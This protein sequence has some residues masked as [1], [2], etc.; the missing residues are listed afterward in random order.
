[1]Q[2]TR[3]DHYVQGVAWSPCGKLIASQ[4]SDRSCRVLVKKIS[5]IFVMRLTWIVAAL[6]KEDLSCHGK[7]MSGWDQISALSKDPAG[8]AMFADEVLLTLSSPIFTHT[9]DLIPAVAGLSYFFP[10]PH[11]FARGVSPFLSDGHHGE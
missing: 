3:H 6:Q 5:C 8:K 10:P 2:L 4:S 7:S 11:V 9:H 1:M